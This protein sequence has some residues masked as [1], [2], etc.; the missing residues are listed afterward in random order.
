MSASMNQPSQDPQQLRHSLDELAG[1]ATRHLSRWAFSRDLRQTCQSALW[2][3][4]PGP[5]AL[6]LVQLVRTLGSGSAP[7]LPIWMWAAAAVAGPIVAI[8]ARMMWL[9]SGRRFDRRSGLGLFDSQLDSKDRLVTA[10]EFLRRPLDPHSPGDRFKQAAIDDAATRIGDALGTA[11]DPKPLPAWRLASRSWW[12]MFAAVALVFAAAWLG[13]VTPDR[14]VVAADPLLAGDG[15]G[16][17]PAATA[18]T[19]LDPPPARPRFDRTMPEHR[20][21]AAD[22]ATSADSSP[23]S[24]RSTQDTEGASHAGGQAN[25]RS[26][27]NAMSSSGTPSNSQMPSNPIDEDLLQDQKPT[28]LNA[29]KRPDLK[30]PEMQAT[31]ATSGQGQSKSSSSDTNKIPATDQPDRAGAEKDDGK[32]EGAVQDAAEEEKTSGVERPSLRRNKPPVDR[33]LSPRPAGD[34]PD[35]DAN[36]RSGPSGRKKTRGVPAMILGIPTPDRIQ[37]TS[38]PGRSKVTQEHSTPKEEPQPTVAAESRLP[39]S[40]AFGAVEHPWLQPWMQTLIET[41]FLQRR[42]KP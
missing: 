25:S 34:E 22:P 19:R 4:L 17:T 40:R 15:L 13:W 42:D 8:A 21:E 11:L 9:A 2:W 16:A 7:A 32:D 27:S 29:A 6:F 31:S 5:A 14:G 39:R 37:G 30:K 26:L 35:P 1:R 12:S 36:G 41:Y 24:I 18:L 33:N 10:D 3:L 23:R 38:S 28:P 20:P